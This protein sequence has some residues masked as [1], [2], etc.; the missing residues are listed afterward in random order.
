MQGS[1]RDYMKV[2]INH[3]LLCKYLM[4]D[5]RSHTETLLPL[6]EDERF[7][8]FDLWVPMAEPWRSKEIAA[9]R[10]CGRPIVY[11]IGDRAGNAKM[12]PP[13]LLKEDQIYARDM[14]KREIDNGLEMGTKKIV[15]STGPKKDGSDEQAF[16]ALVEFYYDICHHVPKDVTILV[17]PTD[18]DFDKCFFIGDSNATRKLVN[19]VRAAGAPNIASMVDSGHLPE[20]HET[21][22]EAVERLGDL[23]QHIHLGTCVYED[24]TNP[25]YGDNHPA[26][27]MPG[28]VTGDKETAD[29]MRALLKTGYFN[30]QNP[31]T[32]T[33]EMIAYDDIHY[34]KAADRFFEHMQR[35]WEMV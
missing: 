19:A 6:L 24:K 25:L 9:V 12:Y 8:L 5:D 26:W 30:K 21:P 17:E 35:A 16:N 28:T 2:G 18:T 20:L 15:T 11:N 13:S 29:L 23:V 3:H 33:F 22:E 31:G 34:L 7:D 10:A 4:T 32:A 1:Y 27:G 14:F